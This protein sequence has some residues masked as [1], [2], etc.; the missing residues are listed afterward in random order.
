LNEDQL[1]AYERIV[2]DV[3]K[4]TCTMFLVDGYSGT[5]KTYMWNVLSYRFCYEG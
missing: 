3:N 5:G 4:E 1:L 2:E